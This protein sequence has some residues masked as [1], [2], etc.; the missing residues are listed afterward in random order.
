M[1]INRPN[2]TGLPIPNYENEPNARPFNPK[3][4]VGV[5]IPPVPSVTSSGTGT[6][7][8]NGSAS[9]YGGKYPPTRNRDEAKTTVKSFLLKPALTSH[10]QCWFNPPEKVRAYVKPYYNDE[11][12]SLSCTEASLPGSSIITNEINDDYTGVTQRLGYRRQYDNTT[13]FTFYVDGGV[14]NGGYNVIMLFEYWIRY[15][16]NETSDAQNENYNYRVN[17]PKYYRSE[18]VFVNKFERDYNGNFLQYTFIQAYPVSIASM[19]VSYDSSQLLK[20]TVS[21]TFDRYVIRPRKYIP[22]SEPR[23]QSATGVPSPFD[24]EGQIGD[25]FTGEFGQP[26][27]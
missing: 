22:E 3:P 16:M 24:I 23:P 5:P 14:L 26:I 1:A 9:S 7:P 19:P 13:D 25:F 17:W 18:E 10:F 2:T 6:S 4:A 27:A 21:F 11:F 12:I 15:A 8:G 20:C